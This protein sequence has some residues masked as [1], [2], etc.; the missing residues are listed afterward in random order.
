[1]NSIRTEAGS[2]GAISSDRLKKL[3]D[4]IDDLNVKL[5]GVE[6]KDIENHRQNE[7]EIIKLRSDVTVLKGQV[8]ALDDD[9][10]KL[11]SS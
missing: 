11:S 5:K 10:K 9:I 3:S 8:G 7:E 2:E 6:E 1:M 4:E